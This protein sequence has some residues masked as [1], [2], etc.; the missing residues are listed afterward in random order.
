MYLSLYLSSCWCIEI[1]TLTVF[2]D[3]HPNWRWRCP[4]EAYQGIAL[5]VLS[6]N[7]HKCEVCW[8]G[9][10]NRQVAVP[11]HPRERTETWHW[12]TGLYLEKRCLQNKPK[13]TTSKSNHKPLP[14]PP[15]Y[16]SNQKTILLMSTNWFQVGWIERGTLILR[17]NKSI[18]G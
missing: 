13:T 6:G 14:I 15:I 9:Q 17:E 18:K 2:A 7:C 4:G 10:G 11:S 3:S 5:E 16:V 1:S 8:R 12:I